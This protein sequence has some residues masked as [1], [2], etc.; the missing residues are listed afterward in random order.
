VIGHKE[1]LDFRIA[2]ETCADHCSLML[3]VTPKM[4]SELFDLI[5]GLKR[6]IAMHGWSS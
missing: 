1:Q 6:L 4:F 5:T 2:F 3:K